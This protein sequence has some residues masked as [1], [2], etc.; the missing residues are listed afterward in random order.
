MSKPP[1]PFISPTGKNATCMEMLQL[2]LDGQVTN[3]QREYF[4]SHMDQCM[5]CFKTF[6]VDMAIKQLVKDRCCGGEAPDELIH[7]IKAQIGRPNS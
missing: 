5:P 2:M 3:E 7:Q 1:N 4:R 6:Q